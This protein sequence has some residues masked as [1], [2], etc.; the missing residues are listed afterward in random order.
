[1]SVG[2][3]AGSRHTVAEVR[4]TGMVRVGGCAVC[5]ALCNPGRAYPARLCPVC[6]MVWDESERAAEAGESERAAEADESERAAQ[7]DESERA[8]EAE[9]QAR[10]EADCE[11]SRAVGVRAA[12]A[13]DIE[14]S[15]D[16]TESAVEG[17][18]QCANAQRERAHGTES[19]D[20]GGILSRLWLV[21]TE[22]GCSFELRR[23]PRCCVLRD[24]ARMERES[25][26]RA[27]MEQ[28]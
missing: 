25:A 9:E 27:M 10:R 13:G 20:G 18:C 12:V 3:L 8:A 5:G 7:A 14:S 26:E 23:R 15:A 1:M 2:W 21:E 17:P 4:R 19:G 22:D 24:W 28:G 6:F 11:Q 16:L